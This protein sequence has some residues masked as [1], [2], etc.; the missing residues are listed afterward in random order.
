ML[1]LNELAA[2]VAYDV[3]E[4]PLAP[5]PGKLALTHKSP[6]QLDADVCEKVPDVLESTA[7]LV[8]RLLPP[9]LDVVETLLLPPLCKL[10][11]RH[12]ASVQLETE[13]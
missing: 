12:N 7:G 4:P 11:L 10:R 1:V 2:V 5:I 9:V 6:A 13:G 8:A 3:V